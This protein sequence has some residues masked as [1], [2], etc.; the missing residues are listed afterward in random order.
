MESARAVFHRQWL[1]L[2]GLAVLLPGLAAMARLPSVQAGG[3]WGWDTLTWFWLAAGIPVAH[4][5]YVWLCWRIE[6][7]LKG[8]SR[9]LGDRAFWLFAAGFALLGLSRVAAVVILAVANRGSLAAPDWV[10]QGLALP[11]LAPALYLFY[12]VHRYFGFKRA[13]GADHFDLRYR[14]MPL[15]REGIFRYTSNGMY[16]YGFL[17]LWVP[18]LWFGSSAAVAIALFNHLYIWVHYYATEK[19]DMERIYGDGNGIRTSAGG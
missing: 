14:S 12:S 11:A 1:H 6:L 15:V 13:L 3:L 17:I 10:G 19:P 9:L 18:G 4:Q 7:H 2:L 8:L 5:G 16:V